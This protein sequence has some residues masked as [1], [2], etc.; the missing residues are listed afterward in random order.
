MT[1]PLQTAM[2]FQGIPNTNNFARDFEIQDNVPMDGSRASGRTYSPFVIRVVL[3]SILGGDDTTLLQTNLNPDR[4]PGGGTIRTDNRDNVSYSAGSR[5]ARDIPSG[6]AA[7]KSLVSAGDSIPGLAQAT[8]KALEDAYNEALFNQVFGPEVQRV[9]RPLRPGETRPVT[10][11]ITND[12]TALS[13][14]LQLKRL[15][16]IPPLLM[17]I[18]PTSMKVDYTKVAQYTNL[19][20]YGFLYEAWGEEL[21][22]I[23]FTFRIGAYTAGAKSSSDT[24][25]ITGMQRASRNDSAS[26]QQLMAML[27]LFQSGAVLQDTTQNSRAHP[28]VGNLAIE[29]DQ[30]VYVGHMESF[31]F[32]DEETKQ[33]GGIEV[34][35][36]FVANKI[37][38]VAP[39]GGDVVP[40]TRP[41]SPIRGNILS[42]SNGGRTSVSFFTAPTIGG[43]SS[44]LSEIPQPWAGRSLNT[45]TG[46]EPPETITTRRR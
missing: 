29:Y 28:M 40:M 43:N 21:P 20:R 39:A 14:A 25:V 12:T 37:Y 44:V 34:S 5:E 19:N 33:H 15:A 30:M 1:K 6:E 8:V 38:D 31:S 46:T 4:V 9:T 13:L 36:D 17:L 26:Y 11:A 2:S 32:T 3:P 7:Y 16:S 18:N 42:R 10:P 22:K 27:S 23:S 35:L 41:N 45:I 24:G